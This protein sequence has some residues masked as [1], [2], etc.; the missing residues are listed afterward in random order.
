VRRWAVAALLLVAGCSAPER[1]CTDIGSVSG[2]SVT[3]LAPYAA[4][5][6]G[7][8]LEVCWSGQCQETEV[9]LAPG[10]DT[11]DQGCSGPDPDDVCS[12]TAVPNNTKVGFADVAKLPAGPI[13]VAATVTVNGRPVPMAKVSR[14]AETTFPN[15]PHCG[16]G[17]NQASV[18]IDRSG[19]R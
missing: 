18:E 14:N 4:E 17:G 3:V 11:V 1:A 5:V 10:S 19:I 7:V 13:T 8:R 2:I 6:D 15:G 16:P 12:A 9:E